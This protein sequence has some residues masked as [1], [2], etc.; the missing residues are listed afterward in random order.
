MSTQ[1]TNLDKATSWDNICF[2]V[3]EEKLQSLLPDN[4]NLLPSDRQRAIVGTMPDG[5]QHIFALQSDEYT[6][7]PNQLLRSVVDSVAKDYTV[8]ARYSTR[9]DFSINVILP[10]SLKVGNERIYKNLIINN[11]Y[12]GKSPFNIQGSSIESTNE[13]KVKVSY[14]RQICSNG[15]MGWA[16]EFMSFEEYFS[17]LANG[18]PKK[19][20]DALKEKVEHV[21]IE[22]IRK[23]ER[24]LAETFHHKGLN[25]EIFREHLTKILRN[26]IAQKDSV[27]G[28]VYNK[29]VGVAMPTDADIQKVITEA[30]L[31]KKLA[32]LAVERLRFEEKEL[33]TEANLWLVYNAANFALF[34]GKSAL[35]INERFK[36]DQKA[37][38]NIAAMAL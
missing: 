17:W 11:S 33:E 34:N 36:A 12:T 35:T 14:Y 31:P 27:T 28:T 30:G 5:T 22:R 26:F 15:L 9:G 23:E 6:L 2:P 16:D 7:I 38:N 1:S 32:A 24:I 25:L 10:D 4:Y 19:Y 18:Q 37:F 8:D 13:E 3:K 21:N 20:L 29:L